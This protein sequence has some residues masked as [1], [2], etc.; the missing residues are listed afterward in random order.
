MADEMVIPHLCIIVIVTTMITAKFRTVSPDQ[1][2]L[3]SK[4]FVLSMTEPIKDAA[5]DQGQIK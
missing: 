5:P 3:S 2:A 4:L 1:H